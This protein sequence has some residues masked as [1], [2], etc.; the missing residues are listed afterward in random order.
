MS[1][2][3]VVYVRAGGQGW[4]PVD[5][6][7]EL[8]LRLLPSATLTTIDD[9]G[10]VHLLRK[11]AGAVPSP[12]RGGRVL[13]MIASSPAHLAHAARLRQ[14][15]PG[16]S[17]RAAWVIDSFWTERVARLAQGRGHFDHVFVT[18]GDL[19][20]EWERL[21]GGPVSWLPWGS[22]CLAL[23]AGLPVQRPTDVLRLGRQPAAWDD[24]TRTVALAADLGLVAEGRPRMERDSRANQR[25]VREALGR[26]K[27]VLA[28]SN[29]VSPAAY[30]HP[31]RE[32]VTGRWTDALSA[33]ATVA[34]V[35]P[36]PAHHI[37]WPEA[38]IEIDPD[39]P[40]RGLRQVA[41]AVAHWS[42]EVAERQ[43]RLAARHL[44]WRWR[45]KRVLDT[46]GIDESEALAAE[47]AQVAE[48]GEER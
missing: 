26:S 43:R 10:D 23:P 3:D 5:E 18:D 12:R 15:L 1:E 47:L 11:L 36:A 21:T 20:P 42:P 33:G 9:R 4:G 8:C 25:V 17:Y 7:A 28:F 16:Y 31:S 13:L 35:A 37:L 27:F 32:Y 22:D 29:R 44:D 45:I 6:L 34:G 24:D 14:W 38:T 48:R 19:V 41:E 46:L 40:S 30:T 2:V 39:D